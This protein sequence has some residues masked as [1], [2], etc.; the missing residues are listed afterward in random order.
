V[1]LAK[2]FSFV[3]GLIPSCFSPSIKFFR[4]DRAE[5]KATNWTKPLNAVL[6]GG[7]AKFDNCKE[8]ARCVKAESE[9]HKT[10]TPK[11][12]AALSSG[13]KCQST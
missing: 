4:L 5:I 3:K 7:R 9:F 6:R 10:S 1:A 13:K 12:T 11:K 2:C 8:L